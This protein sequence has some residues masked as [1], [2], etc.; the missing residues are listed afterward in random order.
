MRRMR[1]SRPHEAAEIGEGGLARLKKRK[2][3][4]ILRRRRYGPTSGG[5][6]A[7]SD[8]PYLT[9]GCYVIQTGFGEPDPGL[10]DAVEGADGL[11]VSFL[12]AA[13]TVEAKTSVT[14]IRRRAADEVDEEA[15]PRFE[16]SARAVP[17]SSLMRYP[18]GW[19]RHRKRGIAH[20][21]VSANDPVGT[22][23]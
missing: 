3:G 10:V 4:R 20:H 1:S 16:A 15:R 5:R 6:R 23:G 14:A 21:T 12:A 22:G 8:A 7:R 18:A 11:G 19:Y 9:V 17:A 2:G 13:T